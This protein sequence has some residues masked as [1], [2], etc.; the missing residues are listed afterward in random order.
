MAR[1]NFLRIFIVEIQVDGRSVVKDEVVLAV[2]HAGDVNICTV[3]VDV[4]D[5]IYYVRRSVG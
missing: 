5:I 2:G 3:R 4:H 1:D